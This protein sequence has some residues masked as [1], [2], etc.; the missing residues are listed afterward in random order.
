M[1]MGPCLK[2]GCLCERVTAV[3]GSQAGLNF[4]F[5]FS[6]HSESQLPAPRQSRTPKLDAAVLIC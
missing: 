5:A 3:G 2:T 6:S 4:L 1:S